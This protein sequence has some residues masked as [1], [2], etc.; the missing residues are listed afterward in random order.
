M[1]GRSVRVVDTCGGDTAARELRP[2]SFPPR[3]YRRQR[4]AALGRTRVARAPRHNPSSSYSS[5]V[6]RNLPPRKTRGICPAFA[7][8]SAAADTGSFFSPNGPPRVVL[9][10]PR[11]D[12]G[13]RKRPSVYVSYRK[14]IRNLNGGAGRE[15]RTKNET[16]FL[17][18]RRKAYE[19]RPT[20]P[21]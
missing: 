12:Y 18:D 2:P 5:W 16:P 15:I 3:V 10:G 14:K 19:K 11:G 13:H 4:R 1:C 6:T 17:S 9:L 21:P 7:R 20:G 8:T